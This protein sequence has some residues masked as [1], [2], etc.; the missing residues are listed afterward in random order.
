MP[1]RGSI[2]FERK[3]VSWIFKTNFQV[4]QEEKKVSTP[5]SD[6]ANDALLG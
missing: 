4:E 5:E 2:T 1:K 6:A 3:G